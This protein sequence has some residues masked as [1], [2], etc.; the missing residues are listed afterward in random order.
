[1]TDLIFA[2]G[3]YISKLSKLDVL[4]RFSSSEFGPLAVELLSM[5]IENV[6]GK[7]QHEQVEI[8]GG[9]MKVSDTVQNLLARQSITKTQHTSRPK[10]IAETREPLRF[11]EYSSLSHPRGPV[12][13]ILA[14]TASRLI[15]G[16]MD[17]CVKLW[18]L[19]TSKAIVNFPG[20][21]DTISDLE[22]I[23][24]TRQIVSTSGHGAYLWD[25]RSSKC[26]STLL[27][28]G[29][30]SSQAFKPIHEAF[31]EV[32][33]KNQSKDIM[34]S[35]KC[36]QTYNMLKVTKVFSIAHCQTPII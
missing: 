24:Q 4:G 12:S 27:S 17:R 36:V 10:P 8:A 25:T 2:P 29:V 34:N 20:H 35:V 3:C 9:R 22:Y 18:D 16:G 23:G 5:L 15:S 13:K 33:K 6:K 32:V 28:S 14:I 1:M 30:E 26:V 31:A 7:Q 19:P 11:Q 21:P